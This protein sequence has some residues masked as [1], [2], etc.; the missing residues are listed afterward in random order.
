MRVTG[1]DGAK[2]DAVATSDARKRQV[3]FILAVWNCVSGKGESIRA[4]VLVLLLVVSGQAVSMST[5]N[6]L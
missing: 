4:M 2:A 5:V 1:A 6:N 3:D